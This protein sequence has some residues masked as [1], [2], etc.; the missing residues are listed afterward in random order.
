MPDPRQLGHRVGQ[1]V[2]TGVGDERELDLVTIADPGQLTQRR[3][4]HEQR[5]EQAAVPGLAVSPVSVDGLG[6]C[7]PT[8]RT[9][10]GVVHKAP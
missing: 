5:T 9:G 7:G 3:G 2:Q 1:T 10:R 4:R 8:E 6:K